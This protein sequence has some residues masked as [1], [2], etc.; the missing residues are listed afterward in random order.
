MRTLDFEETRRRAQRM[1]IE[2]LH[3]SRADANAAANA[4][5]ALECAGFRVDKTGGYYRDE[6]GVYRDEIL[7]RAS[8]L[9][10]VKDEG[11]T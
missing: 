6:A 7:R 4:S 11:G 3:W 10:Y 2:Q 5:D 9:A 1:T 8:D